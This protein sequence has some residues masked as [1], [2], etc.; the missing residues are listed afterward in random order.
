MFFLKD[1]MQLQTWNKFE[2]R[3]LQKYLTSK[4]RIKYLKFTYV[5]VLDYKIQNTLYT[6]F[7]LFDC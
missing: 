3:N 6:N 5:A 2:F 7:G 4:L 1:R